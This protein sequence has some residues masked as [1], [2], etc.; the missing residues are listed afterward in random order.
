MPGLKFKCLKGEDTAIIPRALELR[1]VMWISKESST[2]GFP[3]KGFCYY[4]TT[5]SKAGWPWTVIPSN[6]FGYNVSNGKRRLFYM[7]KDSLVS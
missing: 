5:N 2:A 7:G 6:I 3:C 4:R 1:P